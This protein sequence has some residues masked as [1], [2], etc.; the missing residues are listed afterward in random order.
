[1]GQSAEISAPRRENPGGMGRR[2]GCKVSSCHPLELWLFGTIPKI[3]TVV[4]DAYDAIHALHI[5]LHYQAI[6]SG[7]GMPPKE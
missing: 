3:Y 5:E 6:A 4:T 2:A 1:M 7:V